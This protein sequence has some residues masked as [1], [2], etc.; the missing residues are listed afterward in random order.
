MKEQPL[1]N[2][3]SLRVVPTLRTGW[4]KGTLDSK[5]DSHSINPHW[6]VNIFNNHIADADDRCRQ[7]SATA[8]PNE[9]ASSHE[10]HHTDVF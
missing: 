6:C 10:D 7:P 8:V 3:I 5:S 1:S 9:A 4:D 2:Y